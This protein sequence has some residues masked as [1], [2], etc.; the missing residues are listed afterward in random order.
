VV[1]EHAGGDVA[2]ERGI[3]VGTHCPDSSPIAESAS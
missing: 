2:S 1:I 3:D